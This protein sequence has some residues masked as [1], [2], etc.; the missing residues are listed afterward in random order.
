MAGKDEDEFVE[1]MEGMFN[2][3]GLFGLA[4]LSI[5]PVWNQQEYW[6]KRYEAEREQRPTFDWYE[7][8]EH[9]SSV[10]RQ[11]IVRENRIL[12]VGCGT[13]DLAESLF[14]DG[15]TSIV[16]TDY[17]PV[18][19]DM[20][21]EKVKKKGIDLP[22]LVADV[23]KMQFKDAEFDVV[24][25]KATSDAI[26]VNGRE[27]Q[28]RVDSDKM[29]EEVIRV[30]G[31]DGKWIV[32]TRKIPLAWFETHALQLTSKHEKKEEST[33]NSYYIYVFV[34]RK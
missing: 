10:L 19:V 9:F 1:G 21:K 27:E 14:E 34:K 28:N 15:F 23:R 25:D 31:P 32:L 3:S 26:Y 7:S 6:D 5:A 29:A 13:S 20:M 4:S 12:E 30:L 2:Q 24:L 22:F 33:D 8:Y 18:C 11:H 17:S 16:S